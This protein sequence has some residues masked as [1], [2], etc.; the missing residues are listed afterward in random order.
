MSNTGFHQREKKEKK[1]EVLQRK[2]VLRS[3]G[4]GGSR[5]CTKRVAAQAVESFRKRWSKPACTVAC[6]HQAIVIKS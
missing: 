4:S 3:F 6:L 2:W 5:A 1:R